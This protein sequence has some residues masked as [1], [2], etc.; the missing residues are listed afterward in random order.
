MRRE[1]VIWLGFTAVVMVAVVFVVSRD[2]S[3]D[4]KL[5]AGTSVPTTTFVPPTTATTLPRPSTT[6]PSTT[7][8]PSTSP[9]TT[10]AA[11]PAPA[12]TTGTVATVATQP[13]PTLPPPTLPPPTAPPPT[14]PPLR[15]RVPP[16]TYR[17]GIDLPAGIYQTTGGPYCFW[18]RLRTVTANPTPA[19]V[20][21]S[22]QTYG[23]SAVVNIQPT[24][25][26]FTTSGCEAWLS[27]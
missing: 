13:P 21:A 18:A 19:D 9:P 16:G 12:G 7:D 2:D 26:A 8:V 22:E 14:E 1:W 3:D 4:S 27:V 11:A 15:I 20:I 10:R 25:A 6:S 24:D 5:S 17:V 23:G